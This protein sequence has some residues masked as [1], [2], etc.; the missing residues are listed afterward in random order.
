MIDVR[1]S[2]HQLLASCSL[3]SVEW[4]PKEG[5]TETIPNRRTHHVPKPCWTYTSMKIEDKDQIVGVTKY[6]ETHQMVGNQSLSNWCGMVTRM[7]QLTNSIAYSRPSYYRTDSW[8]KI[9]KS[10]PD[11][12]LGGW[13]R[14]SSAQTRQDKLLA[15][16]IK[17]WI[18]SFYFY[19]ITIIIWEKRNEMLILTPHSQ[20]IKYYI[21][22]DNKSLL[23]SSDRY[24]PAFPFP[25]YS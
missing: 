16:Q 7:N 14:L 25:F 10:P 1:F 24:H 6:M 12:C 15:V 18:S 21:N 5:P 4:I 17:K 8:Q 23:V 3:H 20:G 2:P 9:R 22:T 13:P 19:S 11:L